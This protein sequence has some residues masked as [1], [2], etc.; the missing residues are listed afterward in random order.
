M[1]EA[2]ADAELIDVMGEATRDALAVRA[3]PSV[4]Q[5]ALL[6]NPPPH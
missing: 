5:Q 4:Q 2:V 6:Q 1:F 3:D